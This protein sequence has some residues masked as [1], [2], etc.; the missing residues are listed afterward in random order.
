[1][2]LALSIQEITAQEILDSYGNP[3]VEVDLFMAK[4]MEGRGGDA[5]MGQG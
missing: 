1:M 2:I 5:G 3:T 4:G